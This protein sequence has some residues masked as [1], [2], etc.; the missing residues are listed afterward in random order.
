MANASCAGRH[1]LNAADLH[2]LRTHDYLQSLGHTGLVC[3]THVW[4]AGRVDEVRL[5]AALAALCR[6]FPVMQSRLVRGRRNTRADWVFTGGPG[7]P[8]HLH[9]LPDPSEAAVL[10]FAEGLLATPPD[11]SREPPLSFHLL[12]RPAAG[13]VLV[14]PYSHALMDG[15]SPEL[16]LAELER[17]TADADAG[18]E[19]EGDPLADHLARF[20]LWRRFRSVVQTL[21]QSRRHRGEPMTIVLPDLPRWVLGPPRIILRS[22]ARE[23]SERLSA[24]LR[25][26]CGYEAM[27]TAILASSF[28][29]TAACASRRF[30]PDARCRTF[31][32][33]NLRQSGELRPIFH[34]LLS[35][36][37]VSAA[38]AELA[39]RDG[40]TKALNA[41]VRD[42]LRRGEDL[43]WLQMMRWSRHRRKGTSK[44]E[45]GRRSFA[46]SFHGRAVAGFDSLCG[47]A[48]ERLFTL[49]ATI[50]PPGVHLQANQVGGRLHLLLYFIAGAVPEP[51]ANA[52][53]DAVAADL[54][55]PNPGPV[56]LPPG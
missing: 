10:G 43:G 47:T 31:I 32:P 18:P 56:A 37:T 1:A 55:A 15:R 28:R 13:D 44:P 2:V 41:Q 40:L 39:D 46:F 11:F 53:L 42:A 51:L 9:E 23:D 36:V 50:Y 38:P 35:R 49:V 20:S 5:Q 14:L 24:R 34:N 25:K 7:L 48:I 22:L 12:R 8:L 54:L 30:G 33:L 29:A 3:Q 16:L 27:A 45:S 19:D 52:F 17:P 21:R 4:C 6:R 26:L